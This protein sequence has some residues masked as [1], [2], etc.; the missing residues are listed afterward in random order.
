LQST[1]V[2]MLSSRFAELQRQKD[3][4]KALLDAKRAE[5]KQLRSLEKTFYESKDEIKSLIARL[6][7]QKSRGEDLYKL[8]SLAAART[9]ALVA[10]L[11]IAVAGTGPI[12]DKLIKGNE[13]TAADAATK[14]L[15]IE[16]IRATKHRRYFEVTFKDGNWERRI[17]DKKES[18]RA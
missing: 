14:K 16:S 12:M 1:P 15:V 6:Q 18:T 3:E 9:K 7:N 11:E 2:E 4:A 17:P 5:R 13:A 8:R 10:K